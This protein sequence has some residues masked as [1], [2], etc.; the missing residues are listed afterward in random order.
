MVL[1]PALALERVQPARRFG[2]AYQ[3]LVN[4]QVHSHPLAAHAAQEM[5]I[6]SPLKDLVSSTQVGKCIELNALD[7]S[8]ISSGLQNIAVRR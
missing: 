6:S 8:E 5:L 7:G 3:K 2:R 4:M 1:K